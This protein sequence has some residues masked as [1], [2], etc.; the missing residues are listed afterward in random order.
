LIIS[1]IVVASRPEHLAG[2]KEA[3]GEIPWADVHFSDPAGRLV[4]TIE[5]V[6]LD[7]SMDRLL[8]LQRL[9][10]VLMAELAQFCIEEEV[11]D[12]EPTGTGAERETAPPIPVDAD[13]Q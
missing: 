6:D 3:V 12:W 1:G 11:G 9:P 8:E 4:V 5:A 2:V 13:N 10:R 7:Q